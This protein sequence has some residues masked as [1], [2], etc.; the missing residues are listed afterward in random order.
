MNLKPK[1]IELLEQ[2]SAEE[3]ALVA[4]LSAEERATPGS[5]EHWS[6]K[7][8][9]AHMAAWRKL[10]IARLEHAARHIEPPAAPED[11]D[12]E[13][14]R[15]FA[16]HNG[17][18]WDEVLS[19]RREIG[20]E[21]ARRVQEM[22]EEALRE[23][24]HISGQAERPL[25]DAVIGNGYTHPILHLADFYLKRG[26]KA[27]ALRLQE[28]AAE[29]LMLLDDAPRW[30]GVVRYNLACAH[31]LSGLKEKAIQELR[32]ALQLAPD[33]TDWSKRDPDFSPLRAEPGYQAIYQSP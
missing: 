29:R 30:Q 27:R 19:F 17:Q 32:E 18:T 11:E 5:L 21:L 23:T 14:A 15:I 1:L 8:M 24:G 9:I 26:D 6:A 7:D 12:E 31:A 25:W 13:N 28:D 16:A 20:A 2:E 4:S 22:S 10:S 3:D 33:L